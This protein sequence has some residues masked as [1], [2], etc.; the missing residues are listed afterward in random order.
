MLERYP[1]GPPQCAGKMGR[2]RVRSDYEIE[3]LHDRSRIDKGIGAFIERTQGFDM[4]VASATMPGFITW[5]SICPNP[6][7]NLLRPASSGI[8][9]PAGRMI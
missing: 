3:I 1:T 8:R 7:C 9:I 6:A 4:Q 2:C 5:A